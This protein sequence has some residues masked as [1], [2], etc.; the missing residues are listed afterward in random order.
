MD[1]IRN[2]S[3]NYCFAGRQYRAHNWIRGEM[4]LLEIKNLSLSFGPISVLDQVSLQIAPRETLC[5]VG[6]SGSGKSVTA[7]SIGRLLASPPARYTSGEI[8]LE[9]RDTLRA[10]KSEIRQIRGGVV[11]YVFQDPGSSLNPVFRIGHQILETLKLH[12]PQDATRA[13]VL[14]LLER[15]RISSP[16]QRIDQYPHELSGGMQQRVMIAIA[17]A[18]QPKLLVADEPTTALDVTIQAQIL[19]LLAELQSA[20]GMSILFIT[21]NLGI[22]SRLADRLAV[23]YAGQIVETGA[24]AEVLANP[25]HP[26]TE[27]LIRSVPVLGSN[28]ERLQAIPGT[29]P[30]PGQ[31]PGGC[32]FHPRCFKARPDCATVPPA[33]EALGD[34]RSVRCRYWN[35]PPLHESA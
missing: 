12:R 24:A 4:P 6:E 20:F 13:E 16:D 21:H 10:S 26:Y 25:R 32:R 28:H 18:S 23:M 15:V 29:V 8:L 3:E 27:S 7:L 11:S 17:I 31:F 1:F 35:S 19:D 5:V 22:V 9:G 2:S 30:R 33:L 34:G 14:R